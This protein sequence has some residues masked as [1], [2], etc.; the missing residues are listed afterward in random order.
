[1]TKSPKIPKK[2][3]THE[4]GVLCVLTLTSDSAPNAHLHISPFK[5]HRFGNIRTVLLSCLLLI[6]CS[7][8]SIRAQTVVSSGA[9]SEISAASANLT[10]PVI[11]CDMVSDPNGTNIK[12]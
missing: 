6:F 9:F 4:G 5:H 1:M 12:V 2:H 8:T 7:I 11:N 10:D 3:K